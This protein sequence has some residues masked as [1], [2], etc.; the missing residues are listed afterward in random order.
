[1]TAEPAHTSQPDGAAS[2][3]VVHG[4]E[5]QMQS[6]VAQ[7]N[8]PYQPGT[9]VAMNAAEPQAAG[10]LT[11]GHV[12]QPLRC[13]VEIDC[14]D[15]RDSILAVLEGHSGDIDEGGVTEAGPSR[16]P[17][18]EALVGEAE[19]IATCMEPGRDR[20]GLQHRF[21]VKVSTGSM[22]LSQTICCAE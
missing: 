7:E 8:V 2:D 1:M 6:P 11:H 10:H 13:G 16:Q 17:T 15:E 22:R 4:T 18:Q 14:Q 3:D 20:S 12:H 21:H 9:A 19:W 5:L